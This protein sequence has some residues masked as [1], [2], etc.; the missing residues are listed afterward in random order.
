LVS[1]W[2]VRGKL[3]HFILSEQEYGEDSQYSFS[4]YLFDLCLKLLNLA[5]INNMSSL[6]NN[7]LVDLDIFFM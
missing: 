2:W 6:I 5:F 3:F 7:V 1:D 4:N